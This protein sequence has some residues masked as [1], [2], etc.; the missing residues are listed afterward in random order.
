MTLRKGATIV[1]EV[2]CPAELESGSN[3]GPLAAVSFHVKPGS[4]WAMK[5]EALY[6]GTHGVLPDYLKEAAASGATLPDL[7]VSQC[8]ISLNLRYGQM[9]HEH[10]QWYWSGAPGNEAFKDLFHDGAYEDDEGRPSDTWK[11]KAALPVPENWK[12]GAEVFT[13]L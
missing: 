9:P 10:C 4:V 8:R 1:F 5:A 11:Q 3:D 13:E 7:P 12:D 2:Y 6:Q